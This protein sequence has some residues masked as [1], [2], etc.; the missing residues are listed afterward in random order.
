MVGPVRK[1]RAII[2]SS[3]GIQ[4]NILKAPK[5]IAMPKIDLP[6]RIKLTPIGTI[7]N[8]L[9]GMPKMASIM[10]KEF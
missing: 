5:I 9:K 6:E 10:N 4:K 3:S 1:R 8:V 2:H 7:I